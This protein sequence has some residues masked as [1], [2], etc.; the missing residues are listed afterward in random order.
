MR[1]QIEQAVATAKLPP[2]VFHLVGEVEDV[3]PWL[4]SYD[5]LVLPSKLDGRPVVVME[6]LAMGVAVVASR[7]GAL[8][9]LIDDGVDGYLCSPDRIEEFVDRLV[10]LEGDR[11]LLA[12]MKSAARRK[13]QLKL[14]EREM[15]DRYERRLRALIAAAPV[16]EGAER[17]CARP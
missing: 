16:T 2:D 12:R 11:D 17:P 14:D 7:V 10:R 1:A 13:A 5:V 6:S 4:R 3:A 8:P 9:E 15:L